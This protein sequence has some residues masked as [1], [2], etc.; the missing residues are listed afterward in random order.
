MDY[1]YLRYAKR[2]GELVC[3]NGL[4]EGLRLALLRFLLTG[5][6]ILPLARVKKDGLLATDVDAVHEREKIRIR[7]TPIMF[8]ASHV[9][10]AYPLIFEKNGR[11]L[12]HVFLPARGKSRGLVVRFHGHNAFRHLGVM[13]SW[14]H[15]D[16]L[17]PWD[18]FGWKRQ[19]SWFWGEKGDGFVA[20]MVQELIAG[21]RDKSPGLPW[22]CT[23]GSMGGFG[24][25]YHGIRYGCDGVYVL[26]P[27]VDLNAKINDYG[28]DVADNP[29][30]YL[31]G[32]EMP[33]PDLL[34]IAGKSESLPPLFLIQ[35]QYDHVNPFADHAFRLL[36]IYNQRKGWYGLR[37]HP[38]VGHDGDGS[39]EEAELFFSMILD[40]KEGVLQ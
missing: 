29:Y 25:L 37:V 18:T 40:R 34:E 33:E 30:A 2:V 28:G 11:F 1:K 20:E 23:G 13:K 9:D 31:R 32:S 22:F 4:K 36:E 6:D 35:N 5:R 39:Q 26:Y 16:V 3:R 8:D 14:E 10:A 7:S 19:G 27:Q 15:F 24:A 21:F 12:R 17:A 38:S